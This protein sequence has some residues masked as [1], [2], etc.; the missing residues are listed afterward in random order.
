MSH[1]AQVDPHSMF[2]VQIKRIHEYKRQMLNVLH[3]IALYNRE[4]TAPSPPSPP[5]PPPP[6]PPPHPPLSL[7]TSPL[8][9]PPI[10]MHSFNNALLR[11][12]SCCTMSHGANLIWLNTFPQH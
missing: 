3:I 10:C 4:P 9:S 5:P 6:S 7:T 1:A 8:P 11:H 2:D 12:I